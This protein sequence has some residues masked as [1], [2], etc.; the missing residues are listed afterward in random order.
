MPRRKVAGHIL[1]TKYQSGNRRTV[2]LVL[3]FQKAWR[4]TGKGRNG[5]RI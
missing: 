3:L 5:G 2:H 1:R 4:A